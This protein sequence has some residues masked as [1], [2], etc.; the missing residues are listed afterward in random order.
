MGSGPGGKGGGE[1]SLESLAIT[2]RDF[3]GSTLIGSGVALLA[4]G[5]PLAAM[6]AGTDAGNDFRLG[7]TMPSP[8]NSLDQSWTGYGGVGDYATANGNTHA[9]VNAARLKQP[10]PEE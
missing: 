5:A 2:R 1:R 6:G 4:A 3:V 7:R 8:L 10:D 9:V